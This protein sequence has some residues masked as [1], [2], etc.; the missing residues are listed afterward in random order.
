MI[1]MKK[2]EIYDIDAEAIEE[3]AKAHNIDVASMVN[4]LVNLGRKQYAEHLKEW[5]EKSAE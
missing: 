2:I 4:D 3:L 1:A 5:R